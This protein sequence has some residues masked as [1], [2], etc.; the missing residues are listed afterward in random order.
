MV[1]NFFDMH[2]F[3]SYP[4]HKVNV[5]QDVKNKYIQKTASAR[6]KHCDTISQYAQ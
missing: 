1:Q 4:S 3:S 5:A 6:G 2:C